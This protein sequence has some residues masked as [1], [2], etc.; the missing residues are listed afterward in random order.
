MFEMSI[1]QQSSEI[2]PVETS[3]MLSDY[4]FQLSPQFGWHIR[5]TGECFEW[6]E[7]FCGVLGLSKVDNDSS[8]PKIIIT[9]DSIS[10]A[11]HPIFSSSE[12]PGI[13]W[14][15]YKYF[16]NII[17]YNDQTPDLY[18]QIV[19]EDSFDENIYN[20]WALIHAI[21]RRA[22][23]IGGTPFH[24]ALAERNGNGIIFA[25]P[26]YGGK[27]TTSRRL[28]NNFLLHSDDEVL[29]LPDDQGNYLAHPFPTWSNFLYKRPKTMWDVRKEI[30]LKA[31][32]FVAK[33][34]VDEIAPL[35]TFQA[36][37]FYYQSIRQ[38][39][40]R[41]WHLSG[42]EIRSKLEEK[43]IDIAVGIAK[44]VPAFKIQLTLEGSFEAKLETVL[45]D[46]RII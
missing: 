16:G 37:A 6:V 38:I 17:W 46:I 15:K 4:Q 5:C 32:F 33:S 8:Q 26:G 10:P 42:K 24:A 30:P 21:Y 1:N 34:D 22:V 28:S 41:G 35:K 12:F 27:S 3:Q 19:K 36:S 14:S 29:V 43:C 40:R 23:N 25:A 7:R 45:R 44:S 2:S 39:M 11:E 31:A 20:M 9:K 18:C 13:S